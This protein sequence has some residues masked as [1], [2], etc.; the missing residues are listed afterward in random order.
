MSRPVT[1][2]WS[3]PVRSQHASSSTTDARSTWWWRRSASAASLEPPSRQGVAA[4]DEPCL[5]RLFSGLVETPQ[6]P[7]G[8]PPAELL[9]EV[10]AEHRAAV[11]GHF[12]RW[13]VSIT[14]V[15]SS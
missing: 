10:P 8:F 2:A 6:S 3:P 13:F 15:G 5:I 9:E 1:A 14:S 4:F 12:E 11:A 7:Y